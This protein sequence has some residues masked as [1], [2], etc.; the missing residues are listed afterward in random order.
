MKS[1]I[2]CIINKINNKIY[3]GQAKDLNKRHKEH[4]HTLKKGVHRN[5]H[6][7]KAYNKYGKENFFFKI[8]MYCS[9][10]KLNE[11]E[12]FFIKV[13]NATSRD[14]GY[15][16]LE[17]ATQNP[18]ETKEVREK[19]S[20]AN[21]GR[22]HTEEW[23][24]KASYWNSGERN[25]MY[26]K[27]GTWLGK[28]FTEEH[29]RNIAKA[30]YRDDIPDGHRLYQEWKEGMTTRQLGKKYGCSKFL[31]SSRIKKCGYTFKK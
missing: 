7:Q 29:K 30:Q 3:V 8:L 25:A 12:N 21:K 19:I 22:P 17:Y 20:K 11:N 24:R 28:K 26:G 15:N 1:G 5:Q 6:L 13:F 23:K 10:D 16:I 18:V 31:I 14:K 9:N 27:P 2:Y 4:R